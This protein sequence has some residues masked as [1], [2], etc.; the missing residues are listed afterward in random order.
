MKT[1]IYYL[2]TKKYTKEEIRKMVPGVKGN[3]YL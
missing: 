3:I 1:I 2:H